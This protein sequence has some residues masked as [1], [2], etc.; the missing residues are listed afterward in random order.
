MISRQS[1][2][3]LCSWCF[4]VVTFLTVIRI[5]L[6]QNLSFMNLSSAIY[7]VRPHWALRNNCEEQ[8]LM[9]SG[10]RPNKSILISFLCFFL[11][12]RFFFQFL[13]FSSDSL[14]L[15]S[16]DFPLNKPDA[17]CSIGCKKLLFF[18]ILHFVIPID[19][20]R[21][22]TWFIEKL[23]SVEAYKLIRYDYWTLLLIKSLNFASF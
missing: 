6:I 1:F 21:N 20:D 13:Y 2:N 19:S 15:M 22:V 5:R 11:L 17:D 7:Q 10:L 14:K 23:L 12:M 4:K 18:P 8:K 3:I 16:R 9:T